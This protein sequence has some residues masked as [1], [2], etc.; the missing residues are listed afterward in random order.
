M[1]KQDRTKL[2]LENSEERRRKHVKKALQ[3]PDVKRALRRNQR[4]KA[5]GDK[6]RRF[7]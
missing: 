1:S 7:A 5:D 2:L 6:S 4:E 3:N